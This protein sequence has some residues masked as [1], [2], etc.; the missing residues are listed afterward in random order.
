MTMILKSLNIR[1]YRVQ[2]KREENLYTN[3]NNVLKRKINYKTP[4]FVYM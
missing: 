3:I 1:I 4:F 2:P